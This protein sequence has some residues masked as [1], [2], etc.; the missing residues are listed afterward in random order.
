MSECQEA[1]PSARVVKRWRGNESLVR[2]RH[3][4]PS[5]L[6]AGRCD[7]FVLFLLFREGGGSAASGGGV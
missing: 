1:G 6:I 3:P 7:T 4:I 5:T 2:L